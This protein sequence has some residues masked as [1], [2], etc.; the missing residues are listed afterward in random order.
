MIR[1]PMVLTA[2]EREASGPLDEDDFESE[3][4]GDPDSLTGEEDETGFDDMP[5]VYW[6]DEMPTDDGFDDAEG[7]DDE[8]EDDADDDSDDEC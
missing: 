6:F 1:W 5:A 4:N 8:S 2:M 3:A 7:S